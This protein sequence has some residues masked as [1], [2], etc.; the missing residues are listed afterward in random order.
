MGNFKEY[1]LQK[2]EDLHVKLYYKNRYENNEQGVTEKLTDMV[3]YEQLKEVVRAN[4][5]W[6][7]EEFSRELSKRINKR[8]SL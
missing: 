4:P 7:D 3:R 8:T 6:N 1:M 5:D 2:L